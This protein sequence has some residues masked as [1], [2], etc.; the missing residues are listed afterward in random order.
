MP[1]RLHARGAGPQ[2][3]QLLR[4]G[5]VLLLAARSEDAGGKAMA[6]RT[7]S[8]WWASLAL[9][10]GL[11]FVFLGERLLAGVEGIGSVMTLA[12]VVLVLAVTAAR[13]FTTARTTGPRRRVERTLLAC[14][15]GTVLALVLYMLST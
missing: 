12:G 4:R 6:M 7:A 2:T 15:A 11:I 3:H 10:L 13:A 14:H 8:P 1:E 5:H 9:G